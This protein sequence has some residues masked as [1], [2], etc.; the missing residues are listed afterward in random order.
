MII[1]KMVVIHRNILNI[2]SKV[3]VR[4]NFRERNKF[5]RLNAC[6]R[7]T[8]TRVEIHRSTDRCDLT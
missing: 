5:V 1:Y 6:S 8:R 2:Q 4:Q 3:L 7:E